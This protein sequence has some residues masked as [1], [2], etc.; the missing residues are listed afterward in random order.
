MNIEAVIWDWQGTIVDYNGLVRNESKKFMDMLYKK[1]I[2]QAIITNGDGLTIRFKVTDLDL[3]KYF[4]Y[5]NQVNLISPSD[6]YSRK[7]STEMFKEMISR[8]NIKENNALFIGDD[9]TDEEMAK[10]AKCIF[11]YVWDLNS[12]KL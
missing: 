2:P 4:L 3:E 12:F 10:S 7:P 8:L 5:N 9:I 6:G 1:K 11:C